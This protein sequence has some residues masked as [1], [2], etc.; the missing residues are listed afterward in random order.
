MDPAIVDRSTSD[1]SGEPTPDMNG[2]LATEKSGEGDARSASQVPVPRDTAPGGRTIHGF[3]WFLVCAALLIIAFLYGLDTTIAA[4]IQGPVVQDFGRVDLLA[5]IGA[6][7][8]L[9][10]A[11]VQLLNGDLYGNFNMKWIYIG[12]IVVFEIGSAI[13]G[14]APNMD[15]LIVGRVLAGAGGSAIYIGELNY[16]TLLTDPT[17]RGLYISLIGLFWSAGAVIGPVIGGAF[18]E[19]SATW[20]WAFYINLIVGAVAAPVYLFYLPALR[21]APH[22][23]PIRERIARIDFLGLFLIGATWVL[24]TVAFTVAGGP[25]P[26]S[27]G[28]TIAVLTVFAVLLVC[29]VAQQSLCIFTTPAARAFPARVLLGSRTQMLLFVATACAQTSLFVTTYFIPIYFQFVHSDS[30]VRAAVRL[31]P[32][33]AVTAGLSVL[34]GHLLSRLRYYMPLYL[35]SGV[36]LTAGAALLTVYLGDPATPEGTVYAA[37]VVLALGTGLVTTVGYTVASLTVEAGHVGDAVTL[38]NVSQLGSTVICLVVA[39]QVFQSEAVRNLNGVFA[40]MGFGEQEVRDAVAGA[41]SA[42]FRELTGDM[43]AAAIGAI[44]RAIQRAFVLVIVGGGVMILT[45]AGMKREA[46]RFGDVV[47]AL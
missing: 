46:L 31:L 32:Y 9:G 25:W 10:S 2:V 45:A 3:K 8:P 20:R 4:D 29:S 35:A 28:R 34:S 14:A 12:G 17:E 44:V 21:F 11:A 5:W 19:S 37:T 26:W 41:Q 38:Q 33:I 16:F 18:A 1:T 7:F 24:F 27:D 42:L 36:L 47:A 40:G 13:C 30:A 6:G 23:T 43:R 39:G 15:T 22:K